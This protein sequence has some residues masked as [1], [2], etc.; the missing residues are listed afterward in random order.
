MCDWNS[1]SSPLRDTLSR[2][3]DQRPHEPVELVLGAVVGV[4]GER[5]VDLLGHDVGHAR[6]RRRAHDH[7]LGPAAGEVGRAA[8]GDLDDP[9]GV[10]VGEA[11]DRGVQRL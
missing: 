5:D 4:Q 6:H 8:S 7:V 10:G 3:L 9:V 2:D 1:G 11:L